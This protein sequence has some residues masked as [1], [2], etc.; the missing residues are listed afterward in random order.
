MSP[1]PRGKIGSAAGLAALPPQAWK[2]GFRPLSLSPGTGQ[3]APD[4]ESFALQLL[5]VAESHCR[6]LACDLENF[7][8]YLFC[9]VLS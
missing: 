5:K 9:F 3:M 8:H 2:C 4:S 7:W 6:E 1:E